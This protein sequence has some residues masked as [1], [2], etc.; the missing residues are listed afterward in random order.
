MQV[1]EESVSDP[2]EPPLPPPVDPA[3]STSSDVPIE[4]T[5]RQ[6]E[7]AAQAAKTW[8][9]ANATTQGFDAVI[10]Y[11]L[12]KQDFGVKPRTD[13]TIVILG[14][15]GKGIGWIGTWTGSSV[16]EDWEPDIVNF[17]KTG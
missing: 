16:L 8:L 7:D 11:T 6:M 1:P 10:A 14:V 9:R 5:A 12:N 15:D 4:L 17:P 3:T 13:G 2:Y